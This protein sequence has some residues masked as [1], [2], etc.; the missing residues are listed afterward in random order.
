MKNIF[1]QIIICILFLGLNFILKLICRSLPNWQKVLWYG[2]SSLLESFLVWWE[3]PNKTE[4]MDRNKYSI[5]TH[6]RSSVFKLKIVCFV[7]HLRSCHKESA[8]LSSNSLL[9]FGTFH[10]IFLDGILENKFSSGKAFAY[11]VVNV[12]VIKP[13]LNQ[14]IT[15]S[16]VGCPVAIK[17]VMRLR[18]LWKIA[19]SFRW[20][21]HAKKFWLAHGLAPSSYG[22][23]Q[24]QIM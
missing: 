6:I 23:K 21:Q 13:I 22:V 3:T 19:N 1:K 20:F 18:K 5:A 8:V 10:F 12:K 11:N 24:L 2:R 16:P 7:I 9:S 15:T 4:K 14:F 17:V